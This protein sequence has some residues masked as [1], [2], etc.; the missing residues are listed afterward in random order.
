MIHPKSDVLSKNIGE[1]TIIWQ[2]CVVLN[3]AKIG[4]NCNLCAH[5]FIENNVVIGDNVTIKNGVQIWDGITI[6]DDVFIGPNTT[7]TN[8]LI[9]RS[10]NYL[11]D[12]LKKTLIKK[13]A[14]I[15]ANATILPGITIGEFAFIGAGSVVTTDVPS[16]ALFYGNP[17]KQKGY[18]TKKGLIL[19]ME[20]KDKLGELHDLKLD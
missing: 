15:G 5:V 3:G 2:F 14:T 1:D 7:F 9:P 4:S 17:A 6:E 12:N 16:H 20:K 10:K 8:E 13:G 18:I 19:D 11:S